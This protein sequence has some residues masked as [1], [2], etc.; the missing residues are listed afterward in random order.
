M[1]EFY[2]S[3]ASFYP[4]QFASAKVGLLHRLLHNDAQ[5]GI[6]E[7]T[8]LE[9]LIETYELE[10]SNAINDLVRVFLFQDTLDGYLD[11][12]K[13]VFIQYPQPQG[14]CKL[15]TAF[16][17]QKEYLQ[18]LEIIDSHL[19]ENPDDAICKLQKL[20]IEWEQNMLWCFAADHDDKE[21]LEDMKNSGHKECIKAAGLLKMIFETPI[22]DYR[23]L[24]DENLRMFTFFEEEQKLHEV[25]EFIAYPN[26]TSDYINFNFELLDNENLKNSVIEIYDFTGK[27]IQTIQLTDTR[28]AYIN[29]ESFGSGIY[30]AILWRFR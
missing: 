9:A 23:I 3:F 20:L 18:A 10:K 29:M 1:N 8:K 17:T 6:S 11:S 5:I 16:A 12:V 25:T 7:R 19:A 24:P 2:A 13:N 22:D 14:E 28:L 15:A 30:L 4:G 26:P 27:I 21:L